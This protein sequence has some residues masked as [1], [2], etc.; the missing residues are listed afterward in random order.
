MNDAL[1]TRYGARMGHNI[2]GIVGRPAV[3]ARAR[4]LGIEEAA[5]PLDAGLAWIP[6]SDE[7]LDRL[8]ETSP[9]EETDWEAPFTHFG[10]VLPAVLVELSA[11]GPVAYIETAYTGGMGHQAAAAYQGGGKRALVSGTVNEALRVLGVVALAG[12]DEWDTVGLGR[13]RRMPGD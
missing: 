1:R 12:R 4:D 11:H 7:T 2:T 9:L 3:L 6:L 8:A 5:I 13:H 10:L